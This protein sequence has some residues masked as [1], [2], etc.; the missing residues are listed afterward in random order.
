[1][2]VGAYDGITVGIKYVGDDVGVDDGEEDG[3][4]DGTA[5]D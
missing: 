1:M 3:A 5:D 4:A 2:R